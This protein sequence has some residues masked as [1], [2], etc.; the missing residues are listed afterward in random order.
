MAKPTEWRINDGTDGQVNILPNAL[1][2]SVPERTPGREVELTYAFIEGRL[3]AGGAGAVYGHAGGDGAQYANLDGT[4]EGTLYGAQTGVVTG[5]ES[6]ERLKRYGDTGTVSSG[7]ALDGTPHYRE[8]LPADADIESRVLQFVPVA[9]PDAWG[10]FW[11][12][13][14]EY[15]DESEDVPAF[16]EVT[17]TVRMLA[18]ADEYDA[19]T[20]VVNEFKVTP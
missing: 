19:R 17:L 15:E 14:E 2:G 9:D 6:Y 12:V 10:G 3:T 1:I 4:A 16:Y 20:E 5:T 8:T 11:A 7:L 18:D 13:V